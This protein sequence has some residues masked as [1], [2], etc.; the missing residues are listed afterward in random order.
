MAT[1]NSP[2]GGTTQVA[3]PAE[4]RG[5]SY[6]LV[7]N[8]SANNETS[9]GSAIQIGV[10]RNAGLYCRKCHVSLLKEGEQSAR[11]AG[12]VHAAN[13]P[14]CEAPVNDPASKSFIAQSNCFDWIMA[15][16]R[17]QQP[18]FRDAKV[19]DS[20]GTTFDVPI[21]L[22]KIVAGCPVQFYDKIDQFE[23]APHKDMQ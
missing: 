23:Q 5:V 21:F 18:Q 4:E 8:K 11:Y 16:H 6:C 9:V 1:S 3:A 22:S 12:K 7:L 15:P 2:S 14:L 19:V 13:C 10:K 17:L 20:Y